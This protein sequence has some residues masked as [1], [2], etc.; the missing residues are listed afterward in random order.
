MTPMPH[1]L[2]VDDDEDILML[3]TQFL[4][5]HACYVSLARSGT[6]MLAVLEESSVDVIVL[7]VMLPDESGFELCRKL[8]MA[9]TIPVIMLTAVSDHMERV[10]GLEIGAD[11]YITKPFNARELL[12]RIKAVLRRAEPSTLPKPADPYPMLCFGRWRL[13]IRRRELRLD[14]NTL[15]PLSGGEFD[16][17]LAFAEKPQRVL[18][19]DMLMDLAHGENHVAFDRSIDVQVSRLRR[20]LEADPKSPDLIRTVRNGGY[21]LMVPVTRL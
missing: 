7:D 3:L 15:I 12:A 16:L 5:H 18:T 13:D 2:V 11:D 21:I 19:R 1:V 10:V 8:R 17:L 4:Q 20:K 14:D 6:E 9:S